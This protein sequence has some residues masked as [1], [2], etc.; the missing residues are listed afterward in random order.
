MAGVL[1]LC[2]RGREKETF[3]ARPHGDCMAR[4]RGWVLVPS[5]L[6]F[7]DLTGGWQFPPPFPSTTDMGVYS[8]FECRVPCYL[9]RLSHAAN[10]RIVSPTWSLELPSFYNF[11]EYR[12]LDDPRSN[13]AYLSTL[14]HSVTL[15]Y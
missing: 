15:I 1:V 11:L 5:V 3:V 14:F 4:S 2:V 7:K 9:L 8:Y 10:P 6:G 12:Q 13:S